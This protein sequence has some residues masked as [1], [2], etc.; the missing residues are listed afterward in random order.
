MK[1]GQAEVLASHLVS[2]L[3]HRI[4]TKDDINRLE[5]KIET[6]IRNLNQSLLIKLLVSQFGFAVFIIAVL[7]YLGPFQ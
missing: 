5:T 6:E 4:A 7:R 2:I 1:S 3:D